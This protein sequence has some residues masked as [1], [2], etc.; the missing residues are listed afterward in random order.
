M[1][2]IRGSAAF[3]AA[4]GV[5]VDTDKT[6]AEFEVEEQVRAIS[7]TNVDYPESMRASGVLIREVYSSFAATPSLKQHYLEEQASC[8]DVPFKMCLAT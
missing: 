3:T 5:A 2:R 4:A 8:H 7:G 1:N 6:Y